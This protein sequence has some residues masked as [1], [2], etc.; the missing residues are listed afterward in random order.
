MFVLLFIHFFILFFFCSMFYFLSLQIRPNHIPKKLCAFFLSIYLYLYV[1]L[2]AYWKHSLNMKLFPFFLRFFF[3]LVFFLT[4]HIF[5][6]LSHRILSPFF[7]VFFSKINIFQREFCVN[8]PYCIYQQPS[9]L[10]YEHYYIP[11]F[12]L[13][14]RFFFNWL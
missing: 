1:V 11:F 8:A 9:A 14:F 3:S 10:I 13:S 4:L 2:L 12:S 5:R 7:L 6:V